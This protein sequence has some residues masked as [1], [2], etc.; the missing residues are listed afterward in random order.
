MTL[1]DIMDQLTIQG[2]IIVKIWDEVKMAFSTEEIL[3]D[4]NRDQFLG[5]KIRYLYPTA[6]L[7][8]SISASLVF[9]LSTGEDE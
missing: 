1:R 4:S 9:E 8:P 5:L 3:T 7:Y 2:T 6:T